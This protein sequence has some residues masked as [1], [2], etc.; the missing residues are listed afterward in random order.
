MKE[1]DKRKGHVSI[2][3]HMVSWEETTLVC[4]QD[5]GSVSMH[6]KTCLKNIGNSG[7]IKQFCFIAVRTEHFEFNAICVNGL[8]SNFI[9]TSA[10]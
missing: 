1:F 9:Q 8:S 6:P 3:L 2:K 7:K 5:F 4:D 10:P